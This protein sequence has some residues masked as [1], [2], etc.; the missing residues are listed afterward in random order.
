MPNVYAQL[1]H[2]IA[3]THVRGDSSRRRVTLLRCSQC[4]MA[5]YC[6]TT[7]QKQAW[8]SHKR[9]C[10]CLRSLLPRHPTDSVRLAARLIFAL[11]SPT[12][13]ISNE[14]YTLEEHESHLNSMSEQKKQGLSQL[15]SI[16]ELYVQQEDSNLTQEMTSALPPSCQDPLNLIAKVG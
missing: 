1:S 8:S 15:A 12:K 16:L 6:N 10:K 5:R 13:S 9:E 4:K 14:L 3:E 7:C 11:L 2:T